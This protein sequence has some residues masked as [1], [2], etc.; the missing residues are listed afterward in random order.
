M[1]ARKTAN[2]GDNLEAKAPSAEPGN[3]VRSLE[4]VALAIRER[5]AAGDSVEKILE[6]L[7]VSS[8]VFKELLSHSY[9]LVGT[10]PA[11]FEYQEKMRIGE[12]EG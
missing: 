2:T 6:D 7:A 1:P 4:V 10:A 8:H 12:I 3:T 5:F 9:K 11:V